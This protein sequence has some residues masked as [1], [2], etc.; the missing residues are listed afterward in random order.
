MYQNIHNKN[1]TI[2][3]HIYSFHF[4]TYFN[5]YLYIKANSIASDAVPKDLWY[6]AGL[7]PVEPGSTTGKA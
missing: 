4:L 6:G 3:K 7:Q 5:D 2:K 1:N